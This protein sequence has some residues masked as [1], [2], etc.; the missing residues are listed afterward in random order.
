M[1]NDRKYVMSF[2]F[3]FSLQLEQNTIN[4]TG[5]MKGVLLSVGLLDSLGKIWYTSMI[6]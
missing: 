1:H 5:M 4:S 6:T 2:K 3:L